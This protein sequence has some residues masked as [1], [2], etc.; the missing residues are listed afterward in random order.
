MTSCKQKLDVV[1]NSGVRPILIF[2]GAKLTM[3]EG[4]EYERAR[5]RE[6][7]RRKAEEYHRAGDQANAHKYYNIAV[8]ITPELAN[9]FI[10]LLKE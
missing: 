1:I 8:D 3:K 9:C 7:A 10:R 2:D 6:E 5:N 4:T